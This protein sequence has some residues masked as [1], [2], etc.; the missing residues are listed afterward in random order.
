MEGVENDFDCA[1]THSETHYVAQRCEIWRSAF[2]MLKNLGVS[3]PEPR[4]VSE[5]ARFIAGDDVPDGPDPL[6]GIDDDDE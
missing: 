2:N 6:E 1:C 5:V 4:D 3:E